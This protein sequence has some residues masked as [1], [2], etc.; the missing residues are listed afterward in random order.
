MTVN[1]LFFLPLTVYLDP[2]LL[3]ISFLHVLFYA[4]GLVCGFSSILAVDCSEWCKWP[5][6]LTSLLFMTVGY[7]VSGWGQV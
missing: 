7:A 1:D 6:Y 5:I 2:Y 4:T 3:L